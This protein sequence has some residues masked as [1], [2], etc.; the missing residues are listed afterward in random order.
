MSLSDLLSLP[1]TPDQERLAWLGISLLLYLLG[2][3]VAWGLSTVRF[4][5]LLRST[6]VGPLRFAYFVGLPYAALLSGVITLKSLGLVGV[7]QAEHLELGV[8]VGLGGG[9][10]VVF[11]WWHL[12]RAVRHLGAATGSI[13]RSIPPARRWDWAFGLI[14]AGY[15]QAH[16]AFY[17]ALLILLLGDPYA[18]AFVGLALVCAEMLA[19]PATRYGLATPP[20]AERFAL[21]SSLAVIST[22][23]FVL[24]GTSW[25][26]AGVHLLTLVGV[27]GVAWLRGV[28]GGPSE[29]ELLAD[30][31][32]FQN[33]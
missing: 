33:P 24:T 26:G 25:L 19:D 27:F 9:T 6:L 5:P 1:L 3:L 29:N 15:Q 20:Y 23:L 28:A 32:S 22:V 10:L 31:K 7:A 4:W 14:H 21:T 30:P 12:R 18:G 8:A 2:S 11:W 13:S 17:R 16:W